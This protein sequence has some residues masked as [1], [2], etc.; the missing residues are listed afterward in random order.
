MKRGSKSLL[1]AVLGLALLITPYTAYAYFYQ[2]GIANTGTY[3]AVVKTNKLSY[4]AGE[5]I[6]ISGEVKPYEKGRD[7]QITVLSSAKK[8]LFL[9]VI[10]VNDDATFFASISDTSK[11]GKDIYTVIAQYGTSDVETG[12]TSFSF[13]PTKIAEPVKV[14]GKAKKDGEKEAKKNIKPPKLIPKKMVK[15]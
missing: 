11:W 13:D 12:S 6:V 10:P 14:K 7:L 4:G 2:Q 8:I 1:A 3:T 15:K 9:K 5:P